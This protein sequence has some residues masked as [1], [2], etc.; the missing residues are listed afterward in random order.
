MNDV[1]LVITT[2]P[3][4]DARRLAEELVKR[5]LA[6]C[7]NIVS[8]VHSIYWWEGKVEEGDE[9]ILF[10]KAPTNRVGELIEQ[11]KKIHPYDVPEVIALEVSKG[12]EEYLRWVISEARGT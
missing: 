2:A 6:A 7:I 8:G 12:L 5:R 10:I 11:I 1:S 4:K 3:P 9:V